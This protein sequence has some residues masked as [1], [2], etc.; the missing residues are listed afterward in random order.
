MGELNQNENSY[1]YHLGWYGICDGETGCEEF[2]LINDES[3]YNKIYKIFQINKFGDN[4]SIFDGTYEF[5]DTTQQ[6]FQEFTSLVCGKAYLIVLDK[7]NESLNIKNFTTTK[8]NSDSVGL[9]RNDC[10]SANGLSE[11]K[12]KQN[13]NSLAF[14]MG[15]YGICSECE[16]F[17]LKPVDRRNLIYRVFQI[18]DTNDNYSSFLSSYSMLQDEFQDFST[19]ECGKAYVIIL[20]KGV[21]ELDIQGFVA[22]NRFSENSGILGNGCTDEQDDNKEVTEP[23]ISYNSSGLIFGADEWKDTSETEP[24]INANLYKINMEDVDQASAY[25]LNTFDEQIFGFSSVY[26]K[27]NLIGGCIIGEEIRGYSGVS[28]SLSDDGKRL[29]V[30]ANHN[31]GTGHTRIFELN[32]KN[33]WIQLGKDIDG[34]QYGDFSGW[35]ISLSADGNRIAI[36]AYYND[37][38]AGDAGQTSVYELIDNE[39]IKL[40][41]SING[42][43]MGDR[44]GLSVSLSKNGNILAI[45]AP[46]NDGSVDN[47][48]VS[49]GQTKIFKYENE[50]WNKLGDDI[51]GDSA[52]DRSGTSVFL[53]NDGTKLA[54]GSVGSDVNGDASGCVNVYEFKDNKWILYGNTIKGSSIKDEAGRSVAFN[55][56]GTRVAVGSTKHDAGGE[57]AGQVRIY[58]FRNGAWF[59]LGRDI[60]GKNPNSS[61]GRGISLN[62]TGDRIAIGAY[63]DDSEGKEDNG[64]VNIYDWDGSDWIELENGI[65]GKSD[66]E[67]SG[68]SVSLNNK[69][70]ILAIGSPGSKLDEGKTC[71]YGLPLIAPTPTPTK[72]P[73]QSPTPTPTPSATPTTTGTP[74]LS[75]TPT[76]SKT[77][78]PSTTPNCTTSVKFDGQQGGYV[79]I[80]YY[81]K[82]NA[83]SFEVQFKISSHNNIETGEENKDSQYIV[84]RE[85]Q[86]E[87]INNGCF[88]LKYN[89]QSGVDGNLE[90]GICKNDEVVSLVKSDDGVILRN[91]KYVAHCVIYTNKIELYINGNLIGTSEKT[92]GL[93]YNNEHY[94]HIG[95]K[96]ATL[97][98]NDSFLNGNIYSFYL[99]KGILTETT[100]KQLYEQNKC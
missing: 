99:Y 76:P 20:K 98:E 67:I 16:P 23:F 65:R 52:G 55:E 87:T 80:P 84:F 30:G 3:V 4:Y 94:L 51:Y 34:D 1:T 70:D 64:I 66:N 36:G 6:A 61:A 39:W 42:D 48:K 14:Y 21:R 54:I 7:G 24:T 8:R 60:Y 32:D 44:S 43:A 89:E 40:G 17:D 95:R 47:E 53:N 31:S 11:T 2:D 12:L 35:S 56:N 88:Y 86:S 38:S 91:K 81:E 5:A 83:F 57:D 90:F 97:N 72:T 75:P 19:L 50:Q 82:L 73:S 28:V 45:G 96:R 49:C 46:Y 85:N 9:L 33:N 27:I 79:G 15:W 63:F 13:K 29:A 74:T 92:R 10:F 71:V 78:T 26:D 37:R 69:G 58:E 77:P 100:I 59:K 18:N 22:T 41:E 93:E 62:G 68:F 25:Y